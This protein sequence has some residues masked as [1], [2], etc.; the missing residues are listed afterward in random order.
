MNG[1]KTKEQLL[2]ELKE[3]HKRISELEKSET[4]LK[5]K[6]INLVQSLTKY[7]GLE[8]IINHSPAIVFLW[9]AAEGW[10]VEFVSD[11]IANFGYTPDDFY[12]G[13]IHY[14][15][16]IHPNDLERISDEVTYYSQK[17]DCESYTQEYRIITKD[18][19]VRW[20]DDRTWLRRDAHGKITHYQGVVMDITEAKNAEKALKDS[21][22]KYRTIFEHTGTATMILEE[23]TTVSLVNTE[24]EKISGYTKEE[25]ENK[26][27]WTEFVWE[28]DR[29][30]MK[31]YHADRRVS[32]QLAPEN[33]EFRFI[34]KQGNIKDIAATITVFP[35]T[36][37]SLAS[38]I[39]ITEMKKAQVK[40]LESEKRMHRLLRESFDACLVHSGGELVNGDSNAL[41]IMGGGSLDDF[42]GKPIIDFVHP[43]YRDEV[44]KRAHKMYTH[45]GTVPLM[46]EK[47]VKLDGTPIYVET[48]ATSYKYE[49]K[50]AVQVFFRDITKRKNAEEELIKSIKEKEMLLKE[51]HHRVKNNLMVISS[52]LSLQ[53]RFIKDEEALDIFK[54]S[55][56]RA[57]SMALIHERLY[58]SVDLKRINFADYVRAL[59]IELFHA[60]VADT[61]R[62]KLNMD[63]EDIFLDIN[64]TVPLGLMVNELISNCMKHAFP[65]A[66]NGEISI[67][68][69]KINEG[70][71]L[72]ISDTGVGFPEDLDFHNTKT[73]GLQLVNNLADQIDAK[74]NL[75]R[76]NGTSFT[77]EFKEM[78]L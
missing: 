42:T 14:V 76:S 38:L 64:T 33:Y 32:S 62:I 51:I 49:G 29:D 36:K 28:E 47:W 60:Y 61:S 40:V 66:K 77:I 39:D 67:G 57:K 73:L 20:T 75:D 54:E 9:Q 71:I 55:Q 37:K 35:G 8:T 56:N 2:M 18:G 70:Y 43:D 21:E 27:S 53:S 44:S 50:P 25:I 31:K 12:L 11:N 16:I 52:L 78:E 24:F 48:V 30:R 69:H 74:I 58:R 23:D 45:G 22:I 13:R 72:D 26:K 46:E 63:L 4:Q 41:K 7:R 59:A 6:E 10:P 19:E 17:E 15:D 68:F 5:E 65:D 3:A 1:E 34:D